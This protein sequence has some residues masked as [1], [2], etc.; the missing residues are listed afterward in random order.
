MSA[1]GQSGQLLRDIP[2]RPTR[3]QLPLAAVAAV[4]TAAALAVFI[5]G[6]ED[7]RL[8]VIGL[9]VVLAA[10]WVTAVHPRALFCVFALVLAMVPYADVPGSR[11]PVL[12]V[13]CVGIWVALMFLPDVG[14]RPGWIELLLF[15]W[16]GVAALSVVANG[17]SLEA[18]EEYAAWLAATAVVVPIRFLPP[19]ARTPFLRSYVIGVALA[20]AAGIALLVL[21]PRGAFLARL[22][23]LG[24][25]PVGGN[26]QRV[27]GDEENALRLTGTFVEPNIAGLVLA[28]GLLLAI[29]S[30]RG[31]WRVVLV[32]VIG[33][34]LLLT[35]SRS[36]LATVAV[37][38]VVLALASGRRQRL[39][40]L[41]A[42]VLV[43]VG[44]FAIP[45]VRERLFNSFGPNDTGTQ[46]RWLA[47]QEFPSTMEG[48]WWWGLG[49]AREEF[50]DFG[51]G[52]TVNYIANAPLLT[53][54]RGGVLV[55]TLGVLLLVAVLV[56]AFASLR[57]SFHHA[58]LASGLV[59]FCLV[60]LQLDFP[61]VT[62]AP[63]TAAFSL[64]LGLSLQRADEE[65]P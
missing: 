61:V 47:F 48:N 27:L 37:A 39:A 13:L 26:A 18:F 7:V 10:A 51:V 60:A 15:A 38:L 40:V 14:F 23:F 28:V 58:V 53:Y 20:A 35:L 8:A 21:D 54:Y 30:F 22:S 62:Q 2:V 17:V 29:A 33:A 34:A 36:A 19:D 1:P 43:L 3:A 4:V 63:A 44:A 42:G 65:E 25:D 5:G 12:L 56:W 6:S 24:Y 49:W 55:G 41:A 46:A 52:V 11:I 64:L 31:A 45:T 9:G 59:G 57:R 50:R 32:A 16:A